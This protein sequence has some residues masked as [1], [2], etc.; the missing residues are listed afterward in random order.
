MVPPPEGLI[1]VDFETDVCVL[2]GGIA[3]NFLACLL[4]EKNIGCMVIERVADF[5]SRPLQCAGI[6]SQ[7][8]PGPRRFPGPAD[9]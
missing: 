3:G 1:K 2:G 9:H 5:M 4:R 7:K 8:N 6:V